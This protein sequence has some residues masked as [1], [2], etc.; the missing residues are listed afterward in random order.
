[1][2]IFSDKT[3]SQKLDRAE[4]R[5]NAAFVESRARLFPELGA[6]WID[7]GGTYAMFDG[8]ESPCTQTFGL[9][10]FD[11]VTDAALDELEAFFVE[12]EA[13]VFHEVSPMADQS[14]LE[15]LHRR[16]YRPI[17]L[18]T[19]MFTP[20]ADRAV[21]KVDSRIT[22]RVIG[23]EEADLWTKI[24]AEGWL[25]EMPEM[26]DFFLGLGKASVGCEGG[27]P[28]LAELEGRPIAAGMLLIEGEVALLAG[29]ST[30]PEARRQGAQIALLDARLRFAAERGATFASMCTAPGSQSQKNGQKNG[31][32]IAYTR[33][34]WQLMR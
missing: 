18:S 8:P 23:P 9:G 10:L 11:E 17:E 22:T 7:V 28:F 14:V 32:N 34:K 21:L 30:I 6:A 29:A 19:V 12:R 16:N 13:P 24:S 3:L 2:M 4:A 31:F 1:M 27:L 33:T 20:L 26:K 5:F 15:L 25:A